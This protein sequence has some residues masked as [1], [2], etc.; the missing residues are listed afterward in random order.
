VRFLVSLVFLR[1]S[2]QDELAEQERI[3]RRSVHDERM[4]KVSDDTP[5]VDLTRYGIEPNPGHS[6]EYCVSSS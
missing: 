4:R 5:P 3:L 2:R 1:V 6:C